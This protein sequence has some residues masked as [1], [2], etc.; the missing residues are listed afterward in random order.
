MIDSNDNI[1][2]EDNIV[3]FIFD[4]IFTKKLHPGI[5]LSE[6]VLAKEFDASRDVVRKAFSQL[7][8]MGILKYTKNQG[9]HVVWLTEQDTKD[10]YSARKVIEMGIVRILAEKHARGELDLSTLNKDIETEKYLKVSLKNG[11]YVKTSCDFHLNL[12][13]YCENDFLE[14]ALKPLIPLSILA[15][16]IYGDNATSFCSYDEHDRLVKA[17]ESNDIEK[18]KHVMNHHLDHCIEALDFGITPKKST[19]FSYM[20]ERN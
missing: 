9:F 17:I 1:S 16:L 19:T 11:E 2:L 4:S 20:F 5:K 6:S 15:G 12:A 3:N 8:S 14:N 18:A 13:L 7:Q 10:I